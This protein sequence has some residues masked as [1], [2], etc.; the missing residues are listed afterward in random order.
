MLSRGTHTTDMHVTTF[1]HRCHKDTPHTKYDCTQPGCFLKAEIG[2]VNGKGAPCFAWIRAAWG[3]PGDAQAA[4]AGAAASSP[5]PWTDQLFWQEEACRRAVPPKF[6]LIS[7][8]C[9]P[10]VPLCFTCSGGGSAGRWGQPPSAPLTKIGCRKQLRHL[11]QASPSSHVSHARC[12][13]II[14]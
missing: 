13:R 1:C 4:R 11:P 12:A 14:C 5:Q 10:A 7:A 6:L 8:L 3:A 2:A 9:L